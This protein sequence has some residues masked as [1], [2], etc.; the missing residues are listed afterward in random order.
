MMKKINDWQFSFRIYYTNLWRVNRQVTIFHFIVSFYTILESPPI[1]FNIRSIPDDWNEMSRV[2]NLKFKW[3]DVNTYTTYTTF[4]FKNGLGF[5]QT[6]NIGREVKTFWIFVLFVQI[7][8]LDVRVALLNWVFADY[9][10]HKK[11][12]LIE[13]IPKYTHLFNV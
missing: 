7:Q 1:R 2:T 12:F 4:Q 11:S 5:V 13:I 9:V 6:E 10:N 3:L 8:N